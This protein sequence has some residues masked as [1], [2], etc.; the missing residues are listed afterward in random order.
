MIHRPEPASC[1]RELHRAERTNNGSSARHRLAGIVTDVILGDVSARVG[2]Q[3]GPFRVVSV[4]SRHPAEELAP[5]PDAP[6]VAVIKSTPWVVER[7]WKSPTDSSGR[8]Q[9]E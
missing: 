7:P 5:E 3:P 8:N 2:I 4:L 9:R 6:A 1:A